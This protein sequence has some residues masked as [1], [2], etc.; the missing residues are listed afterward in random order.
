M[1]RDMA[2]VSNPILSKAGYFAL[3]SDFRMR[4]LDLD[5]LALGR[6]QGVHPESAIGNPYLKSSS[7]RIPQFGL[8][9]I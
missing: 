2:T 7:F 3:I 8:R 4:I 9:F 1:I 6:N 5:C